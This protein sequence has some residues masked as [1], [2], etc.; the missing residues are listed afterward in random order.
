MRTVRDND[1]DKV[2]EYY[3]GGG[4]IVTGEGGFGACDLFVLVRGRATVNPPG[5]R[6]PFVVRVGGSSG[7]EIAVFAS[8]G[9]GG[10]DAREFFE[11]AGGDWDD[12]RSS[13][14][15]PTRVHRLPTRGNDD[16]E[17]AATVGFE[18]GSAYIVLPSSRVSSRGGVSTTSGSQDC[19]A[20]DRMRETAATVRTGPRSYFIFGQAKF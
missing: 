15:T 19:C 6:S 13:A 2:D 17:D 8:S 1:G 20:D 9:M 14:A 11:R 3:L 4:E 12:G 18:G 7:P 16:C 5:G 10:R